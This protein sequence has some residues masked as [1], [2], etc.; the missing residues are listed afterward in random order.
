MEVNLT[1]AGTLPSQ[2]KSSNKPI[3]AS[4]SHVYPSKEKKDIEQKR[5]YVFAIKIQL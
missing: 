5:E 4:R 3:L 2:N 1:S